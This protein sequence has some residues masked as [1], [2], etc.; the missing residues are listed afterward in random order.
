M[1]LGRKFGDFLFMWRET[2]TGKDEGYGIS[3]GIYIQHRNSE[4]KEP[5]ARNPM[6][7]R[8]Q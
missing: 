5:F 1:I 7:I 3:L 4:K 8:G 2:H 6:H